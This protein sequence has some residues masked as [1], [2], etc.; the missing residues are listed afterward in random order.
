MTVDIISCDVST[1]AIGV[2]G[3]VTS[4]TCESV[5]IPR[6]MNQREDTTVSTQVSQFNSLFPID[7]QESKCIRHTY[8]IR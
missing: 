2:V 3:P 5:G 7:K 4:V 8:T 1:S 6:S